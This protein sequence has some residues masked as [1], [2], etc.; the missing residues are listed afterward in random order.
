MVIKLGDMEICSE[1][2]FTDND[3]NCLLEDAEEYYTLQGICP[4]CEG[5]SLEIDCRGFG[6][7]PCSHPDCMDGRLKNESNTKNN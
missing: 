1:P 2:I 6:M 7:V 5:T 3:I 4:Y